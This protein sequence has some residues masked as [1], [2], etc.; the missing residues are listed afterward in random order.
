MTKDTTIWAGIDI[1][2]RFCQIA[3]LDQDGRTLE[4][5]RVRTTPGAIRRYF[6]G[7]PQMKIAMEV[8]THSPWLNRVLD[9][10]GHEVFV[11]NASKL[12]LIYNNDQKSDKVD[13][14][15][16]AR[17]CRFDPQLLYPISH[18]GVP[19]PSSTSKCN[20]SS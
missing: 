13:A 17:V 11:A 12:R 6:A 1:G 18:K 2:D 14:E 7:R 20:T 9:K 5:S 8:G 3:L 16:L 15:M 10:E 19:T 4:E